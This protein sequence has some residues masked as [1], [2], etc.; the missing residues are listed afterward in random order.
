MTLADQAA[1][2]KEFLLGELAQ[3]LQ[4][5]QLEGLLVMVQEV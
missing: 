2:I 1:A 4:R 3:S 5:D